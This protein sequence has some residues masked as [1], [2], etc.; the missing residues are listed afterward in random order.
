MWRFADRMTTIDII[1]Q[2]SLYFKIW[3]V[4]MDI[5]SRTHK[6]SCHNLFI[7]D[8]ISLVVPAHQQFSCLTAFYPNLS[9]C[10]QSI[11]FDV[12]QPI[13]DMNY[14]VFFHLKMVHTNDHFWHTTTFSPC[15]MFKLC[16]RD[17][18]SDWKTIFYFLNQFN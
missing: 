18:S 16:C 11:Y 13:L 1:H 15:G 2:I 14:S 4:V 3:Q 5:S 6:L 10:R 9:M 7:F 12:W 8:T 17:S